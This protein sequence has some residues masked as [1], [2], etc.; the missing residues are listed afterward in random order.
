[1]LAS[2][3]TMQQTLHKLDDVVVEAHTLAGCFFNWFTLELWHTVTQKKQQFGQ[4]DLKACINVMMVTGG[5]DMNIPAAPVERT[6]V[7]Y[8]MWKQTLRTLAEDL[9]KKANCKLRS[10]NGKSTSK[11]AGSL[12]KRWRKLRLEHQPEYKQKDLEL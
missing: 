8:R 5:R 12:R 6:E 4:A 9:D 3:G 1:M 7:A 2:I 10:I 11:T